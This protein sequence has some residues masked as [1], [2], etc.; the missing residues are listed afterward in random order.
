M[1]RFWA[2]VLMLATASLLR[3]KYHL[4]ALAGTIRVQPCTRGTQIEK[5][6]WGYG[7]VSSRE[8]WQG[9]G[10]PSQSRPGTATCPTLDTITQKS[11][12]SVTNSD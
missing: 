7:G 8:K 2:V 3:I 12:K 11:Q 9:G 6:W 10:P 5:G 1:N 4:D